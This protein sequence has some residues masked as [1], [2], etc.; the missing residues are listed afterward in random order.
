MRTTNDGL[1]AIIEP[2]DVGFDYWSFSPTLDAGT[3]KALGAS[4]VIRYIARDSDKVI[5]RAETVALHAAGIAVVFNYEGTAGDYL[6]GA[7]GGTANGR[8]CREWARERGY[9]EHLP[10]FCSVDTGLKGAAVVLAGEYTRAFMVA[11]NPYLEASYA[12]DPLFKVLPR[13]SVNW[14]ANAPAWSG[15]PSQPQRW[16]RTATAYEQ[17]MAAWFATLKARDAANGIVV[18]IQQQRTE[19]NVDPNM[20]LHPFP[21]WLPHTVVQPAEP[22][23]VPPPAPQPHTE[24]LMNCYYEIV[25]RPGHKAAEAVFVGVEDAKGNCLEFRWS[26]DTPTERAALSAHI[27]AGM[28]RREVGFG[29][30]ANGA[31][32]GRLP[33][34]DTLHTWTGAEFSVRIG[35]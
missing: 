18:H 8:K 12:S 19:G 31:L 34:G 21:A 23:V 2:G 33:T 11:A 1:T 6:A 22:E 17:A 13:E 27:A 4:Y 9:P 16:W 24:D 10:I 32:V 25:D 3:L 20:T 5:T 7:P 15:I 30:L 29:S 35:A 26:G 14:R 28:Q